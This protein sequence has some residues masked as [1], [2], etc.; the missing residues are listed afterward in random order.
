MENIKGNS[1][2]TS[3][4][5][6]WVKDISSFG[7]RRAGSP[8]GHKNEDFLMGQLT[9]FGLEAVHKEPVPVVYR[10]TQ[11]A[12]LEID[13]GE[14]FKPLKA[15]WIPY[16]AYT[17]GQGI[18][19]NLVYADPKKILQGGD[20]KGKIV[21]TDIS[22]PV[23]DV[24]LLAK[25]SLGQYDPEGTTPDIKHPATWV[26][27]NWHFYKQAYKKGAIGFIGILK[28]QPGGSYRMYAPY[29][30]KEKNILDKPLPG[31]WVS[32]NDGPKLR[33]LAK[34]GDTRVRMI[35][36]GEH[37]PK[38]TNN[39]VG[40]IA[41]Q[42]DEIVI[43][44][45]HHDSPFKSPVE[46]ASGCAVILALAKH[47]AEERDNKRKIIIL[48]TAGH[49]YGSLGTRTFIQSHIKDI[50]PK[51]ALEITIEHI[52]KEAVENDKGE[53][54]FSGQPEGTGIFVPF[55]KGMVNTVLE[56]VKMNSVDRVFLL[57]PEGPLGNY[58]PTDGGDWYEAGVPLVNIISNPVYLLNEE[59]DLEWVM[60]ERLSK[61]AGAVADI[62][63]KT[64]AMS[65]E[66]IGLVEF[67]GFKLKMK[68][69]KHLVRMKT[70][71]LGFRPTY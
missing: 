65:K 23:L 30:F 26:R 56:S 28:D 45:S 57:P 51:V 31:F 34:K 4:M 24:K 55:N 71:R 50:V 12:I 35:H 8:A 68:L 1:F 16:S 7:P 63:R 58:P 37:K 11:K 69:I 64:D 6:E 70:T 49:F 32:R 66:S 9:N 59:D 60:P 41:G 67:P 48:F 53:L 13:E 40:E 52:A 10:E 22:F 18:E 25:F 29:G 61:V 15:Q 17:P 36:T 39:I 33:E 20:W 27:I 2:D 62:V 54:V 46:D 43:L 5:M 44:H 21:L 38:I 42:N 47:F 3:L 14:G 19:G